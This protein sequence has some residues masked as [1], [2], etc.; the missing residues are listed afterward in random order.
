MCG[1]NMPRGGVHFGSLSLSLGPDREREGEKLILGAQGEASLSS[2]AFFSLSQAPIF[3]QGKK[4]RMLGGDAS[5][6]KKSQEKWTNRWPNEPPLLLRQGGSHQFLREEGI[7]VVVVVT[8]ERDP[9]HR[10]ERV[11]EK[12]IP[13][14]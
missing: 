4:G 12:E 6:K 5:K 14:F 3:S 2:S 7:V 11:R 9:P 1:C 13:F 8:R 10:I